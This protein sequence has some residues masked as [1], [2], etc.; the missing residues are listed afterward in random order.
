MSLPPLPY[1]RQE[2][3]EE[4]V[5]EVVACLR[6]DFLTQ[7]PRVARFEE[8]LCEVAGARHA[9]AVANGTAALHLAVLALGLGPGDTGIV[10]AI[11]FVA[12]AN[13]LRYAGA[14]VAFADVDARD[15]LLD[16][17][18][19]E[20]TLRA[21]TDRGR[22]PRLVV[23]VHLAGQ[24]VDMPAVRAIASRYGAFVLEDAAHALGAT[25]EADSTVHAVGGC[26]HSD[27]AIFSFH[28]VKHITTGEGG[29]VLT[30]DSRLYGRLMDLRTH[31]IHKDPDRL[32]RPPED[33][34]V[35]PW[36][37][38]QDALGF[39]YRITDLQCA[40]GTSQLRRLKGNIARRREI[41]SL[42]DSALGEAPL[43]G[44]ISPLR[45]HDGRQSAHH[46][47]V[48]QVIRRD[49]EALADL[50]RRR[51]SLYDH[52]HE[53][54]IR[55]Q[56]HYIPVHWQPYHRSRVGDLQLPGADGYYAASLSLPMFHS[57]TVADAERVVDALREWAVR[58]A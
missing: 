31:G 29:A 39:N 54:D 35:G 38:E 27:A 20:D 7:G 24:P 58:T 11:T 6:D 33:P 47:Y 52:L 9:V 22:A 28:P 43:H 30:N 5:A 48:V 12:S 13:C 21:L 26:A 44:R 46:L 18:H 36:Y 2:V 3:L 32:T 49:G 57:M 56:V 41:A 42:Y 15:G 34:F 53:K 17:E 45:R 23:P 8:A 19:L 16:L 25:Y 1:G 4:D 51:R 50:A 10:P 40:L 37:Y 55:V 14:D